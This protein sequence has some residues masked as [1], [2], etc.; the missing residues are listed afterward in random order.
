M[1]DET[2]TLTISQTISEDTRVFTVRCAGEKVRVYRTREEAEEM[3]AA[4]IDEP[5]LFMDIQE[6]DA[7]EMYPWVKFDDGNGDEE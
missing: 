5:E 7:G 6:W 4:I 2:T 1:S 3:K